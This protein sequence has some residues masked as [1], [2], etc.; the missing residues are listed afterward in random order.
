MKQVFLIVAI[1]VLSVLFLS[2]TFT[3]CNKKKELQKQLT[4]CGVKNLQL[5]K[6]YVDLLKAKTKID[7]LYKR[8]KTQYVHKTHFKTITDTI[9]V[10]DTTILNIYEDTLN[11]PEIR[12]KATI[13]AENLRSIDYEYDVTEKIVI[14]EHVVTKTDTLIMPK[15]KG[16]LLGLV[17]VGGL[18][19]I[20]IGLQYQTSKKWGV[21]ARCNWYKDDKY[22]TI[23][24]SYRIF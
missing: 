17:D 21:I 16:Q 9:T 23:G 10:N 13:T 7:S 2:I 12:L 14:R 5:E 15:Y 20:S 18:D 24:I 8:G 22:Y 11:R 1:F 3:Q 4:E 6:D 19:I